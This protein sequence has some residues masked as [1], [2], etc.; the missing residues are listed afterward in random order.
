MKK[1]MVAVAA[2][3]AGIWSTCADGLP[4]GY[5]PVKW[6]E[7]TGSQWTELDYV[8][9]NTD[10]VKLRASIQRYLD[11]GDFFDARNLPAD[12]RFTLIYR[13]MNPNTKSAYQ[14]LRV[15][16]GTSNKAATNALTAR[17]I[18]DLSVDF[19]NHMLT[20]DGETWL[21]EFEDNPVD[22]TKCDTNLVLFVS[23]AMNTGLPQAFAHVRLF[24]FLLTDKNGVEKVNLLPCVK[25]GIAGLY[26]T[27]GQKFYASKVE[28]HPFLA[29]PQTVSLSLTDFDETTGKA[30]LAIDG[31]TR[32]MN[33]M[34][35][36][37]ETAKF[38][39]TVAAGTTALTVDVPSGADV[40]R[41]NVRFVLTD[42]VPVTELKSFGEYHLDTG[43]VPEPPT[44]I[45]YEAKCGSVGNG[46]CHFGIS[47]SFYAFAQINGRHFAGYFGDTD[48]QAGLGHYRDG[49][50]HMFEFGEK[51]YYVDRVKKVKTSD[52]FFEDKSGRPAEGQT[53]WLFG[54]CPLA[55]DLTTTD[56]ATKKLDTCS[57]YWA[58]ILV[59]GQKVRDFTPCVKDGDGALYD[60]VEGKFYKAYEGNTNADYTAQFAYGSI[61]PVATELWSCGET[62]PVASLLD[63]TP[64]TVTVASYDRETGVAQLAISSGTTVK[65]LYVAAGDHDGGEDSADWSCFRHL[66]T[67]AADATSATVTVPE[68]FRKLG[69]LRF[70]LTRQTAPYLRGVEQCEYI[71]AAGKSYART[72]Y[73]PQNTDTVTAKVRFTTV[74]SGSTVFD[75]RNKSAQKRFGLM[76]TVDTSRHDT[77]FFRID[78]GSESVYYLKKRSKDDA[79]EVLYPDTSTD[80]VLRADFLEKKLYI[81]DVCHVDLLDSQQTTQGQRVRLNACEMKMER[82]LLVG[83][84]TQ[85]NSDDVLQ[86]FAKARFYSLSVQNRLATTV[87]DLVP[88]VMDGVAQFYDR[89]TGAY[90]PSLGE[91]PF[92][93]GG[94]LKASAI[95]SA[96]TVSGL[97]RGMPTSAISFR[98]DLTAW[99]VTATVAEGVPSG[100]IFLA[101]AQE[102]KGENCEDWPYIVQLGTVTPETRMVT[103]PLPE[104]WKQLKL[105]QYRAFLACKEPSHPY[106]QLSSLISSGNDTY[107]QYIDT[108]IV[109]DGTTKIELRAKR[110]TVNGNCEFGVYTK[111][112]MFQ[113]GNATGAMYYEFLG[114]DGNTNTAVLNDLQPHTL[115][116]GP[117]G[118]YVDNKTVVAGPL[119]ATD[120]TD[121]TMTLFARRVDK[122][123][124]IKRISA[125]ISYAKIW[126]GGKLVRDYIPCEKNGVGFFYD[127]VEGKPYEN[128]GSGSFILGEKVPGRPLFDSEVLGISAAKR[129]T[130]G[131]ILILK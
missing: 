43:V 18:Y 83:A 4:A 41:D 40:D 100:R 31:L 50:K 71:E 36:Y 114:P 28:G 17:Q 110:L 103:A 102:D 19:N 86:T 14:T 45:R 88:C 107:G 32:E 76:A 99:S 35:V 64:R 95:K 30:Q 38:V 59:G 3:I 23:R 13:E 20:V 128:E 74:T 27:V 121:L 2:A 49:G 75:A 129:F 122:E 61:D 6:I 8:P 82:P 48:D 78:R 26:D 105:K 94:E 5:T 10:I 46:M 104:E 106:E 68:S 66:G 24:S 53:L 21:T 22:E 84:T 117:D 58:E 85:I 113:V 98:V 101:G 96:E 108:G 29:G 92:V 70:F 87:V 131:L 67:I 81:D 73:V 52:A 44:T 109:P 125:E 1:L 97:V 126:Q 63:S 127:L 39:Q 9:T 93:A 89:V 25:N 115:V 12:N 120:T 15:H 80:Y 77:A 60:S 90:Y 16:R 56:P 130:P 111:Y 112:Y 65:E 72:A 69:M 119:T 55:K 91:E 124:V 116:F 7:A 57:I 118:G 79:P 37:G 47:Q 33:L 34:A 62:A 11:G 54:R 51:G 123:T 42:F